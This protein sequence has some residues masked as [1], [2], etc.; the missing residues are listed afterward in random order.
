MTDDVPPCPFC[1]SALKPD[2]ITAQRF[3][4]LCCAREFTQ[5]QIKSLP[6]R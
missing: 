1:D 6:K 5:D 3:V 4:C 2:R